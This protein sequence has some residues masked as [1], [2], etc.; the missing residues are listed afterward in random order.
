MLWLAKLDADDVQVVLPADG[1]L[2][3]TRRIIDFAVLNGAP[4]GLAGLEAHRFR[5]FDADGFASAR[6]PRLA[7]RS[8]FYF[9]RP[10]ADQLKLLV[11][12]QRRGDGADQAVESILAG[13]RRTAGRFLDKRD[14]VFLVAHIRRRRLVA[15]RWFLC[16]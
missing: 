6:V 2:D 11:L 9:E 4:E 8:F 7:R 1:T 12:L 3:P 5:R 14:E 10:E 16:R 13:F 15:L